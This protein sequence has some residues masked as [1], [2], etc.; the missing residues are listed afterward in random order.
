MELEAL[1]SAAAAKW[2][3]LPTFSAAPVH[4]LKVHCP[5]IRAGGSHRPTM[6]VLTTEDWIASGKLRPGTS[7]RR[8]SIGNAVVS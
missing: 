7:V 3:S 5:P 8:H 6:A 4:H 2:A 1:C